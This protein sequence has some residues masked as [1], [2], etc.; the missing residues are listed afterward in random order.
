MC[1]VRVS[2]ALLGVGVFIHT[3]VHRSIH[4]HA[5][6]LPAHN[7]VDIQVCADV[8]THVDTCI[9]IHAYAHIHTHMPIHMFIHVSIHAHQHAQA[10]ARSHT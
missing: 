4:M 6:I 7:S 10:R 9:Y 1:H 5:C 8:Y 3:S 2:V